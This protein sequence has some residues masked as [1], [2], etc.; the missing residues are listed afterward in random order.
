MSQP[1]N[2]AASVRARLTYIAQ[3]QRADVQFVLTRYANERFLY[4]L[5]ISPH[6]GNFE[7]KGAAL[8]TLWTGKPHRAT[9]DIDMLGFG[10]VGIDSLRAI[11]LEIL[12]IATIDDGIAFDVDSLSVSEILEGQQYGG[13]RALLYSSIDRARTRLQIDIGYGDA[14]TPEAQIVTFPALLDSP[15]P[16]LRAYPRETVIAEKLEA[17]TTLGLTNSRM[18]DF[19]DIVI[20]AR[21]FRIEGDLLAQAI[22]ATFDR[23]KTPLPNTLPLGLTQT[24]ADDASKQTQW[25]AF[26]RKSGSAEIMTLAEAVATCAGFLAQPLLAANHGAAFHAAWP[27]GGPWQI[28]EL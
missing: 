3:A 25:N 2:I 1:R 15:P 20:L 24:F 18:K 21:M 8:F 28:A 23:R 10:E 9:R 26:L 4:R 27:Q 22:V 17:M 19:Y 7:L 13:L 16:R 6:A 5:S 11:L 12:Q 14:I